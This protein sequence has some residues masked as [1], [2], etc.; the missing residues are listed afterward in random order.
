MLFR[1]PKEREAAQALIDSGIDVIARESDSVEPDKLAQEAG[2]YAIG[3]NAISADVAPDALLTAPIWNWDVFYTKAVQEAM[4]GAWTPTPVWWGMK[5]G[6]L[7]LAP[8][9]DFVP[10]D[11]KDLVETEKARII[12][13]EFDVFEGPI[14]DNSG[15]ERLAAGDSMTD[16]QKLA[17]DW[18]VEGVLGEIPQ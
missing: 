9:A 12:A 14:N 3:Y 6:L 10:Q 1:S 15:V 5:E 8:I 2:V 18:L 7:D 13:G 11:V 4:D 17:F 16:E